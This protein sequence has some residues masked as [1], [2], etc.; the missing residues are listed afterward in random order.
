M[1]A[2]VAGREVS[3]SD[4]A[5]RVAGGAVELFAYYIMGNHWHL[6]LRTHEDRAMGAFMKWLTPTHAGRYN[7]PRGWLRAVNTP[8]SG[9]EPDA[10]RVCAQRG[11]PYGGSAMVTKYGLEVTVCGPG[12]PSSER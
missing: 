6:V 8:I 4:R 12:R 2:G 1:G 3:V 7:R 11:R 10:L 9:A 5:V